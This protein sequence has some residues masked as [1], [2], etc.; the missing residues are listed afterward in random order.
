MNEDE[1]LSFENFN[2]SELN[3]N[4]SDLNSESSEKCWEEVIDDHLEKIE[5]NL[6]SRA[7]EL[8]LSECTSYLLTMNKLSRNKNLTFQNS[9]RINKIE[10][11]ILN[12]LITWTKAHL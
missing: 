9:I 10:H 11:F 5:F 6:Y 7:S 3:E 8:D 12:M 4:N 2:N 1:L